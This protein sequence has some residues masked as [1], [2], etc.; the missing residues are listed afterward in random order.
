MH[1]LLVEDTVT[2][3]L[4]L[5][6]AFE[7]YAPDTIC[8]H[9]RDLTDAVHVLRDGTSVFDMAIVDLGLPDSVG[10]DV[11]TAIRQYVP[12]LPLVVLTGADSFQAASLQ[13]GAQA[14]F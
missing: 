4:L 6:D 8:T 10:T 11:I 2:D 14:Y 13:G 1:V 12:T 7:R 3:A 9:V 5:Q